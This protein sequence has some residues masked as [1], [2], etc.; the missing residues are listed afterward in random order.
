MAQ[1]IQVN[2]L[3]AQVQGILDNN[4]LGAQEMAEQLGKI[5]ANYQRCIGLKDGVQKRDFERRY[6]AAMQRLL[7]KAPQV[8]QPAP[9]PR[10]PHRNEQESFQTALDKGKPEIQPPLID[11]DV[12]IRDLVCFQGETSPLYDLYQAC[13]R[14]P[15]DVAKAFSKLP[16]RWRMVFIEALKIESPIRNAYQAALKKFELNSPSSQIAS[17]LPSLSCEERELLCARF[18]H[19]A[20]PDYQALYQLAKL[21]DRMEADFAMQVA[22]S[23]RKPIQEIV[24]NFATQVVKRSGVL[25][26]FA[27]QTSVRT[28][29]SPTVQ[30]V[31]QQ[32]EQMQQHRA[33]IFTRLF[34]DVTAALNE[35]RN[36]EPKKMAVVQALL[37]GLPPALQ[38]DLYK[39]LYELRPEK[40]LFPQEEQQIAWAKKNAL[41]YSGL[42]LVAAI[43]RQCPQLPD[44]PLKKFFSEAFDKIL[45]KGINLD[46]AKES[47][48]GLVSQASKELPQHLRPTFRNK[49]YS[50]FPGK[51]NWEGHG[52]ERNAHRYPFHLLNVWQSMMIPGATAAFQERM[53]KEVQSMKVSDPGKIIILQDLAR[54]VPMEAGEPF[55]EGI[56]LKHA[57]RPSSS[58]EAF[59]PCFNAIETYAKSRALDSL[60]A[61]P[62]FLKLWR[63]SPLCQ[64]LRTGQQQSV[65]P[66]VREELE[67]RARMLDELEG[68]RVAI[69]VRYPI[70]KTIWNTL[71]FKI[72]LNPGLMNKEEIGSIQ[73]VIDALKEVQKDPT[74]EPIGTLEIL[75]QL[76]DLTSGRYVE[77]SI[78]S[79]YQLKTLRRRAFIDPLQARSRGS[80]GTSTYKTLFFIKQDDETPLGKVK[81]M[82]HRV[83][84]VADVS[85]ASLYRECLSSNFSDATG[86]GYT[87]PTGYMRFTLGEAVHDL[88]NLYL[89]DPGEAEEQI[90]NAHSLLQE[91][92]MQGRDWDKTSFEEKHRIVREF[93]ETNGLTRILHLLAKKIQEG[94][95]IH[96]IEPLFLWLPA[97]IQEM[98]FFNIYDIQKPE[99]PVGDYGRLAFLHGQKKGKQY[100]STKEQKVEA[101]QRL[102][103]FT[104]ARGLQSFDPDDMLSTI[105]PW[106]PNSTD[107]V[108]FLK[109]TKRYERQEKPE[110]LNA[111]ELAA[112]SPESV[113]RYVL[114]SIVTGHGDLNA[115]NT[116]IPRQRVLGKDV[117]C[118]RNCDE[119]RAF[120]KDTD[121]RTQRNW[122]L[123]MWQ[124]G[125]PMSPLLLRLIL[126]PQL[127]TSA[128][129][130]VRARNPKG[131]GKSHDPL[132]PYRAE[133]HATFA[134]PVAEVS[135][136]ITLMREFAA[137]ALKT[138]KAVTV[139]ELF[140]HVYG[141]K[142]EYETLLKEPAKLQRAPHQLPTPQRMF[143]LFDQYFGGNTLGEKGDYPKVK[144]NYYPQNVAALSK[145]VV[146]S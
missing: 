107:V 65:T 3:I 52:E 92:I 29:S 18:E 84:K 15:A 138:G 44:H 104:T 63:M 109:D 78:N 7:K 103:E 58:E 121:Y 94:M 12:E 56:S 1:P 80:L 11:T 110:D 16:F 23:D 116:L 41:A 51:K 70:D 141:G 81:T 112:L 10:K 69:D 73:A 22:A 88:A 119:E 111:Q 99:K 127:Q 87:I 131:I 136:R 85:I 72:I 64:E 83:N 54:S 118:L 130:S 77:T 75:H 117:I 98:V 17:T 19:S 21:V 46:K 8:V 93:Y 36:D 123:G 49:F 124:C 139:R 74:S 42:I 30:L 145:L 125:V 38:K 66:R 143:L 142:E 53:Q 114:F 135:R 45:L 140:F 14:T 20:N 50:T 101:I 86:F 79:H 5:N 102:V 34:S 55:I 61:S 134:E 106:M 6:E 48:K 115:N 68:L 128:E 76:I 82:D 105:Q 57:T 144:D 133:L 31:A 146:G 91:A 9:V 90:R 13:E 97:G 33:F 4:D 60:K 122:T 25:D 47:L 137:D 59:W 89:T 67:L 96:E 35:H 71:I 24:K 132:Q 126:H 108:G 28:S 100:S 113:G 43:F 27:A 39:C 120:S 62:S 40:I 2:S 32:F 95:P 37:G 129:A 26:A